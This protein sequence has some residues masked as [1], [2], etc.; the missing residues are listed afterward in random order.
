MVSRRRLL[1]LA[2]NGGAAL[3]VSACVATDLESQAAQC[4]FVDTSD[5]VRRENEVGR[6]RICSPHRLRPGAVD[7]YYERT[8]DGRLVP[9]GRG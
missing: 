9:R 5:I 4:V 2:A 1:T 3:F 8:E 7:Q 6:T